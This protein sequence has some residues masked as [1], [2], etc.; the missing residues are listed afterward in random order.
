MVLYKKCDPYIELGIFM[1]ASVEYKDRTQLTIVCMAKDPKDSNNY[2]YCHI[3]Y[4]FRALNDRIQADLEPVDSMADMMAWISMDPIGLIIKTDVDSI[5]QKKCG[6]Q[7]S[8][9]LCTFYVFPTP[10]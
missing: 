7:C 3:A 1:L 9:P 6:L 2:K 4:N 5:S 10:V 8:V